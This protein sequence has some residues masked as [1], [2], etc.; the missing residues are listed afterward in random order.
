MNGLLG[1]SSR[2]VLYGKNITDKE[3][4]VTKLLRKLIESLRG[5]YTTA[6][7]SIVYQQKV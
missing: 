2:R 7:L 3:K 5:N 1:T 6:D 4:D